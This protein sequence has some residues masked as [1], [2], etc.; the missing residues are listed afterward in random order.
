MTYA[1][2]MWG[3]EEL[4]V[5]QS[6]GR[7]KRGICS[8]R[9]RKHFSVKGFVFLEKRLSSVMKGVYNKKPKYSYFEC[10]YKLFPK[11]VMNLLNQ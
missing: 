7:D 4:S 2:G 8:A 6:V 3:E 11:T 1:P 5:K 9:N 10:L